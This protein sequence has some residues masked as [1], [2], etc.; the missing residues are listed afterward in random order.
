MG[1]INLKARVTSTKEFEGLINKLKQ[2]ADN[3]TR[4]APQIKQIEIEVKIA[5]EIEI[6]SQIQG[7]AFNARIDSSPSTNY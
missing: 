5:L 7:G 1:T 3:L 2:E 6:S 4:T